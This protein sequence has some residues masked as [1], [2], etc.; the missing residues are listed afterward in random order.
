MK[1]TKCKT[2]IPEKRVKLGYSICVDCSTTEAYSCVDIVYH[3]TGNTIQIMDKETAELINKASRR[4]GFGVMRGMLS[5]KSKDDKFETTNISK[6]EPV[7][8]STQEHFDRVGAEA[9][10]IFEIEGFE[11][12]ERHIDKNVK[13][14]FI[15]FRQSQKILN[16][17]KAVSGQTDHVQSEKINYNR[18]GKNDYT[19]SKS[20]IQEDISW[21][22]RNWKK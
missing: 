4:S 17:L 12:A 21:V 19:E 9:M 3:K 16:I 14:G 5:G 11:L 15:S 18:F 2:E 7:F 8:I 22:F 1:C 10:E 13:N 20:K 6:V